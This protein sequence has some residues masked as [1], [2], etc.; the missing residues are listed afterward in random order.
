MLAVGLHVATAYPQNPEARSSLN[1]KLETSSQI[2][3]LVG[4]VRETRQLL[5]RSSPSHWLHIA[6]LC[7]L[8]SRTM[9]YT[10]VTAFDI[11]GVSYELGQSFACFWAAINIKKLDIRS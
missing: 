11:C 2:F 6:D 5:P 3:Y 4:G 1:A 8:C 9:C 10:S 7:P